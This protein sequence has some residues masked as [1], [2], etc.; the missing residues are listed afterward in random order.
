[1]SLPL[2]I[3]STNSMKKKKSQPKKQTNKKLIPRSLEVIY[4]NGIHSTF[5]LLSTKEQ[6]QN[7]CP[8]SV[9]VFL[10]IS[11]EQEDITRL[12]GVQHE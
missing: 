2:S 6:E 8:S 11:K 12:Q 5:S 10:S 7:T 3:Q 1:M 9:R 4:W